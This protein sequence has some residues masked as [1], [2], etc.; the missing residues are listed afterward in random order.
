MHRVTGMPL[1]ARLA[2]GGLGLV[3]A[4]FAVELTVGLMPAAASEP[5]QKFASNFVFIG[6]ALVCFWRAIA[7]REERLAWA[8]FAFGLVAWG[9]GDLYFTLALWDLPEVP[10]PSPADIGYLVLYP[11]FIAGLAVLG[12][13]RGVA[14]DRSL[15]VDAAIG[16]L[17]VA[18]F[19]ATLLFGAIVTSTGGSAA[20]VATNLAY[21]LADL[22]LVAL[23]AGALAMSGWKLNS[24][25]GWIAG[26]LAVFA[27]ADG[28][29][30]DE[31]ALG[32]Y[33]AG[34][35]EDIGWPLAALMV[36]YAA[37]LPADPPRAARQTRLR[38]IAL[39]IGMGL[40]AIGMLAYDHFGRVNVLALGLACATLLAV[41]TRLAVTLGD[42][43]RMLAASRDEARTDALTGLGNRRALVDDLELALADPAQPAVVLALYDLDG[44]KHYNDTFGH[45]AGDALLTRLGGAL[46]ATV[47][48]R[49]QAY[50][51]GGD[52]FCVVLGAGG[53]DPDTLV[54]ESAFALTER[55]EGFAVGCSFGAIRLPEEATT[56]K[57]ALSIVDTR[58]YLD[59]A[60]GRQSAGAQSR[61]VLRQAVSERNPELG[62]HTTGVAVLSGAVARLLGLDR[63]Q[64]E[65]VR[66]AA[67]LHDVG[68][69]AIPDAILEKAGALDDTEWEFMHR[70]TIIGERI[71]GAA[72][73]LAGVAKI[74]RSSHERVD[75]AG[76]PDG[77]SG[78][79]IPLG[80]RI[81][82]ACD[83]FSAMTSERPYAPA[84]TAEPALAE[85]RRCAGSQFDARV[86]AA[87]G[88]VLAADAIGINPRGSDAPR[89]A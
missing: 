65:E 85:L 87:I 35:I 80:A 7:I 60:G 16:A 24:A 59:K 45:S 11:F 52:E 50:R 41:L 66:I 56:T 38:T 32:T 29:Y 70:H 17:A 39:P 9:L 51:M 54:A 25:W 42:N 8:L 26:G 78:E 71:V 18:A 64:I 89:P 33:V 62:R 67:E 47:G 76:Y 44:F 58:M 73:A 5:F 79:E 72:P 31:T 27:A 28:L 61:D 69:V 23:A 63:G 68:K 43:V 22:L 10:V 1:A 40:M 53:G 86:V 88:D 4:L 3:M 6:S 2:L 81:V 30:L 46:R 84:I 15:W 21:P 57:A 13:A 74:V 77:L 55:G 82:F 37:W 83:A 14:A 34:H 48:D 20:T 75:G 49:G 36:A 19:A 12:S